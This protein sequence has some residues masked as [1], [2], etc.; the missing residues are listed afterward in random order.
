MALFFRGGRDAVYFLD[1]SGSHR[2]MCGYCFFFWFYNVRGLILV[3]FFFCPLNLL[4]LVSSPFARSCLIQIWSKSGD[5]PLL[6]IPSFCVIGFC[7]LRCR[8]PPDLIFFPSVGTRK[9]FGPTRFV[10]GCSP[11]PLLNLL[12]S[13]ASPSFQPVINHLLFSTPNLYPPPR[14]LFFFATTV[15]TQDPTP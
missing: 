2:R 3:R 15:Q 8:R 14:V 9:F 10:A 1:S 13:F 7:A 6:L 12:L 5:S 11:F 4:F